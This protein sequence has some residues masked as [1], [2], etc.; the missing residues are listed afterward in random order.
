[1]SQGNIKQTASRFAL[2]A[3]LMFGFGYLLVPLYDVIC[4]LTGLNG[5][6]GIITLSDADQMPIDNSRTITVE[7]DTNINGELPWSFKASIRKM[8][9]H[10]GEVG[11]AGF[12]VTNLADYPVTG[13]AIPSVAPSRGSLYFNKTECFCF[14]QQRLGPGEQR[15]MTVKFIVDPGLPESIKSLLLSYTFFQTPDS[16]IEVSESK[17]IETANKILGGQDI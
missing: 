3:M 16:K 1:M 15:Q 8:E 17:V 11:E 6:T 4:D 9:V 5:K 13:Q 14:S 2:V 10:P 7:F 12:M